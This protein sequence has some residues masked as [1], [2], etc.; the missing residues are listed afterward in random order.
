MDGLYFDQDRVT[1]TAGRMADPA[2]P[3]QFM[4]TAAQAQSMGLR[5]GDKV[6]FGIYT[7]AQIQLADFGTARVR[8]YRVIEAT[9]VGIA[10]FNSSVVQDQA[11]DGVGTGQPVHPG[12]HPAAPQMLRQLQRERGAG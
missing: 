1:V 6:R 5:V 2:A 11:D 3:D 4:L 7:N 10:A 8:P 12:A 9:L